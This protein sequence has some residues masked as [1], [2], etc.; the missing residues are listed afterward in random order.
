MRPDHVSDAPASPFDLVVRSRRIMTPAGYLDGAVAVR[1]EKIAALVP[2]DEPVQTLKTID[3]GDKPVIPGLVDTHVHFRDPGF[4]HKEDFETGSRAAAAGGVTTVLDMCNVEPPTNT[5]ELVRAHIE[6]ARKKSLVDFGHNASAVIPENIPGLVE[7]GATALK[8]FMMADVGRGYPHMPGIAVDNH[9]TLF[10]I[11]EEAA[12]TG[13]VLMVHPHDQAIYELFVQRAQE[14]WGRD[15]RSYARAWRDGDAVVL[16]SGVATL[17]QL[18]RATG[19]RM[20]VLHMASVECFRLARAA[21]AAGRAVTVELNPFSMFL[22]NTWDAIEKWGPYVLGMWVPD[23]DAAAVWEAV[24]DG[25][26]DVIATDH[27]PHTREE[28][29]IGWTDMYRAPGGSPMVQ[30][31]LSLLL[32]AVNAGRLTLE[33][34]VQLCCANPAKLVDIY[35][36]K[37]AIAPGSDAD[38]VVVDMD[39]KETITA[40]RVYYKCGWTALEGR[41]VRGVP[42]MTIL[43]G[44]VIMEEGQV[45]AEP[46]YGKHLQDG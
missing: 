9:A 25:T 6:N 3:V 21:K 46:G 19:V 27:S 40:D 42:V 22:S 4:T 39:R 38:L 20:H 10:R 23:K 32:D 5:P 12:R 16:N 18:Q 45:F 15:Y 28:K 29:E 30:H 44:R 36:R 7:A 37:G 8:I 35:P 14:R 33:K 1:G 41:E 2:A 31:Y 11:C 34:V 26:A 24:N 13:K 43:R 17:M